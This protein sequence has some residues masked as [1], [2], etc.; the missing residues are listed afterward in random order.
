M[1]V[2]RVTPMRRPDPDLIARLESWLAAAKSGELRT[3]G[4]VFIGYDGNPTCWWAVDAPR[5]THA[6]SAGA[7]D[8]FYRLFMR[9]T[10]QAIEGEP[11]GGPDAGGPRA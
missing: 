4:A 5:D 1:A 2:S 9:R 10:E 3:L 7:G 6:F 8:F 11:Y